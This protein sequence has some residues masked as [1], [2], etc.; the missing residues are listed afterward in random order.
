[1]ARASE[2]SQRKVQDRRRHFQ[3]FIASFLRTQDEERRLHWKREVIHDSVVQ[4]LSVLK[5]K[6]DVDGRK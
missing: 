3:G 4:Y 6:I 1:M 2:E 5:M